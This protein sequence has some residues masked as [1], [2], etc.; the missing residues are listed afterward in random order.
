M[1]SNI[2][3]QKAEQQLLGVAKKG[4]KRSGRKGLL[5]GTGKGQ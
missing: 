1:Q 5:R 4:V 3:L 2:Q